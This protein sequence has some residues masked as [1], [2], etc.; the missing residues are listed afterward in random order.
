[1]NIRM[2]AFAT[3]ILALPLMLGACSNAKEQ[4]GLVKQSPDEFAIVKRAPLSMPP[5]VSALP[6]PTPGAPRPQEQSPFSAAKQTVFGG[7]ENAGP[8]PNESSAPDEGESIFLGKAGAENT[9]PNIRRRVDVES[10]EM[11]KKN[12]PVAQKLLN[13]GSKDPDPAPTSVVNAKEEAERLKNN[14]A[15]GKPVTAGTTP[16]VER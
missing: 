3:L 13:L 4:L 15:Q 8:L 2:V 5:D 1:M 6:R 7:S 12:I 9:D 14:K 16:T 10:A 11:D